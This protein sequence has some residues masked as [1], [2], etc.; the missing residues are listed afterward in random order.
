VPDELKIT[1]SAPGAK[2]TEADLRSVAAAEQAVSQ[3][4]AATAPGH[5][6]AAAA[7]KKSSEAAEELRLR[8][9]SLLNEIRAISP[10]LAVLV[11][12]LH[13]VTTKTT[14]MGVALGI[15]G[16]VIGAGTILVGRLTAAWARHRA[17]VEQLNRAI[18]ETYNRYVGLLE[19]ADKARAR[20]P[21]AAPSAQIVAQAHTLALRYQ[22]S[23]EQLKELIRQIPGLPAEQAEAIAGAM[24][25]PVT[26]A[27][28]QQRAAEINRMMAAALPTAGIQA[29][30]EAFAAAESAAGRP[31]RPE[32]VARYIRR[33]MARVGG[34]GPVAEAG[35]GALVYPEVEPI[36]R[37]LLWRF[38]ALGEMRFPGGGE[39][40]RAVYQ[41]TNYINADRYDPAGRAVPSPARY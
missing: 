36:L 24:G 2:A 35:F 23:A 39:T 19:L 21:G 10:E 31:R 17:E 18:A 33:L 9:R 4:A 40:L 15:V 14:G 6:A 29:G 37:D 41:G 27:V 30:L 1:V 3:A 25:I 34:P 20:V 22:L 28:A 16:G 32:D 38:P 11:E 7:K 5:A 8:D 26:P 12:T 13:A